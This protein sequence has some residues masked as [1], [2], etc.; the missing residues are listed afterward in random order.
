MVLKSHFANVLH[1]NYVPSAK[2]LGELEDLV[3]EPKERM[4]RVDEEIHRLQ[5][6]QDELQQFVDD[7]NAL[8]SPF[9]RLPADIWGEI[10]V[11]CL[12]TNKLNVA[13]CAARE[14]PLL[15]T[16]ICRAWREIALNTPRLW[17]ALHVRV[18]GADPDPTFP[19]RLEGIK[20]WLD[21]SGSRPLTLS[22]SMC[23]NNP[24][25]IP[26]VTDLDSTPYTA[27]MDLLSS[28]SRR[29]GT[30]SLDLGVKVSHLQPL[31]RFT[32]EDLPLLETVYVGGPALIIGADPSA[33][34]PTSSHRTPTSFA[35]LL[36]HLPSLR[37]LHS[38]SGCKLVLDIAST[39]RRLTQ[40]TSS[41]SVLPTVA[42]R[43]IAAS[44]PVLG[45][46]T[47]RTLFYSTQGDVTTSQEGPV[48]WP[49]LQEL[50]LHFD[51]PGYFIANGDAY[52]F[53]SVLKGTFDSI[54]TPQ[55][56]RLSIQFGA[57]P[58]RPVEDVVPFQDF[59][60]NSPSL[61]HLH[62]L[63]Y[64]VLDAEALSRCLHFAPSL[65]TLT[66]RPRI[67]YFTGGWSPRRPA[68][69]AVPPTEWIPKLLSSLNGLGSCPEMETFDLGRCTPGDIN[70]ILEFV[71]GECRSSTLKNVR[72]EIGSFRE[73]GVGT[74]TSADI[75][76]KLGALQEAKGISV[77]LARKIY[78]NPNK[79]DPSKGMPIEDSP[80]AS[81][82]DFNK[83]FRE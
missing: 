54:I 37:S 72:A 35:N 9:R 47:L 42:L 4:K 66:L 53:H 1:T 30:L 82:E 61:T 59:I 2:E 28:Y 27:L 14:A 16:T 64:N 5:T 73:D 70:S 58:N 78:E 23:D 62:V 50:N 11:Y 41:S 77:D 18:S 34:P 8:R 80:W 45:T 65:T 60:A 19:A 3:L 13:F 49:S 12:P 57:F 76:E 10:F 51:G 6:E 36:P 44:C 68:V 22:I 52:S 43:Q 31:E 46:L 15:L 67:R 79:D 33:V 26:T 21:R 69:S 40:L 56:Y 74:V 32:I 75:T 20:L 7:H 39:C 81:C 63:G 17:S 71:Q 38:R 25:N 48:V 55:L 24:S 29:W 83:P